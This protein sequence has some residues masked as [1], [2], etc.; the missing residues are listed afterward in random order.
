MPKYINADKLIK[1]LRDNA[2]EHY[3]PFVNSI[4]NSQPAADVVEVV[5]CKDC[6]YSESVP[7]WNGFEFGCMLHREY[8][9][10]TDFCSY[11]E[12]RKSDA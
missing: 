5:R 3:D 12:R 7:K 1:D 11:G 6:K 2:A 10:A 9:T 4:I 8:T